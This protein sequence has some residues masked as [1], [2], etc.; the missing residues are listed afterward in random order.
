MLFILLQ[1]SVMG[2]RAYN[3]TIHAC[4]YNKMFI[5]KYNCNFNIRQN[6]DDHRR[7][8][9]DGWEET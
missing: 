6:R 3:T 2:S 7:W 8:P 5:E 4:L 1:Y 9:L